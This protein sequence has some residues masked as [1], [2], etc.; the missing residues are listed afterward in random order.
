MLPHQQRVI[1]EKSALDEKIKKLA[2][3]IN[4]PQSQSHFSALPE[5]ERT[6]LVRQRLCMEEYALILDERIEMFSESLS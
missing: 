6:I 4:A 5:N 2:T 1:D 3:F